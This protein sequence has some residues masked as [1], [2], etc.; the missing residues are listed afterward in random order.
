M[1]KRSVALIGVWCALG[2]C[3]VLPALEE[4]TG[5]VPVRDIVLRVKCELADAFLAEDG[6]WLVDSNRGKFAWLKYW[7]AQVD[8]S[9]Q[10]VDSASLSPGVTFNQQLHNAYGVAAGPSTISTT[11]VPGTT[12]AAIPQ[13]FA[14]AAGANIGGQAQRSETV[15]FA[16]SR[17]EL[18]FWRQR[19]ETIQ[20]CAIPDNSGLRGSLGLRQWLAEALS[21]VARDN[22]PLLPE[23]LWGGIHPKPTTTAPTPQKGADVPGSVPK[24]TAAE[25]EDIKSACQVATLKKA[26]DKVNTDPNL[27]KNMTTANTAFSSAEKAENDATAA[28][29]S[30]NKTISD[31]KLAFLDFAR[32]NEIFQSVIDPSIRREIREVRSNLHKYADGA[33]GLAL[34]VSTAAKNVDSAN[35]KAIKASNLVTNINPLT[36]SANEVVKGSQPPDPGKL[37]EACDNMDSALKLLADASD[38]ARNAQYYAGLATDNALAV[39][40]NEQLLTNYAKAATDY[41]SKLPTIDPPMS[42]IG[43][44]V[45]FVVNYGGNVTP[46]W[47]LAAFRG[48]NAPLLSGSGT[49]THMLNISLGPTVPGTFNTPN[50]AVTQN[51]QNLLLNNLLGPH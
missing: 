42:T 4:A 32:K 33:N 34:S 37:K 38:N 46:T 45:Q 39:T 29:A 10:I 49:R 47:T 41:M 18:Q 43:Q 30:A 15:S 23:Y 27:G 28:T 7:T 48:P 50:A 17:R 19:P 20:S 36:N 9:L 21:P 12:I 11:G 5:G 26:V 3:T 25:T 14:I 22:D 1:R 2:G 16:L 24:Q 6:K 35:E 13:S 40:H 8:L 31:L 44:S 51:Q